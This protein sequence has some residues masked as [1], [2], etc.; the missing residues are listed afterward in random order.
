[1][2]ERKV[3]DIGRPAGRPCVSRW[4]AGV[5]WQG[6]AAATGTPAV[7]RALPHFAVALSS[8]GM[9]GNK[10]CEGRLASW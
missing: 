9:I 8:S 5:N 7:Q 4:H 10:M 6:V 2:H 1:M 3:S